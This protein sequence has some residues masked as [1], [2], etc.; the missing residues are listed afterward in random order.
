M[1]KVNQIN[2]IQLQ[3]PECA[4]EFDKC[5]D[6]QLHLFS[7]IYPNIDAAS[8]DSTVMNQCRYCLHYYD[9]VETLNLHLLEMH[10]I[11][12]KSE[13]TSAYCCVLCEV[14]E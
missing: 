8:V 1:C 7:H 14:S 6:L 9:S 11:E 2:N 3:C 10:P 5:S 4:A 13:G 12:V